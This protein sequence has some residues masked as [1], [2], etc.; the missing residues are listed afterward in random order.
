MYAYTY[1]LFLISYLCGFNEFFI[2]MSDELQRNIENRKVEVE[3]GEARVRVEG[4][5]SF[6][7][8]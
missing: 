5:L 1:F 3:E 7:F 8:R 4:L 6:V 2:G